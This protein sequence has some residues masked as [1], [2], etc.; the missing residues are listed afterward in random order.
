MLLGGS[1]QLALLYHARSVLNYAVHMAAR[2][3]VTD[4]AAPEAIYTGLARGLMPLFASSKDY[5]S[6][7]A[8]V[9]TKAM[10]DVLANTCVRI[11][12]PSRE[13]LSLIHI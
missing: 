13:A 8:N 9:Y 1:I 12:S 2:S 5:T 10:P 3:A 7:K 11:I 4:Q 6:T